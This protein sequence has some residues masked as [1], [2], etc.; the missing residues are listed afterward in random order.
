MGEDMKI[1]GVGRSSSKGTGNDKGKD[2]SKGKRKLI[3]TDWQS[4][5]PGY[6]GPRGAHVM[7]ETIMRKMANQIRDV[8]TNDRLIA[9]GGVS[10]FAQSVL[11]PE[12]GVHL[13][14]EDLK[15]GEDEARLVM[16]ETVEM[17]ELL[18]D[19]DEEGEAPGDYFDDSDGE[20]SGQWVTV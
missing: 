11:V 2:R 18:N 8:G 12:L 4:H 19:E 10:A 20:G 14:M 5:T 16:R 3:E 1:V 6:Y 13:V 15:V 7:L 9:G 17:G